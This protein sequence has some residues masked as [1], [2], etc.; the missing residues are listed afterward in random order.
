MTVESDAWLKKWR[1]RSCPMGCGNAAGLSPNELCG[2]CQEKADQNVE[3]QKAPNRLESF[4]LE[5]RQLLVEVRKVDQTATIA[6]VHHDNLTIVCKAE[7]RA[8]CA[9]VLSAWLTQHR[10]LYTVDNG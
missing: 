10:Y 9:E 5:L 2:A 6:W 1:R 7:H 4:A 3:Q 8:A